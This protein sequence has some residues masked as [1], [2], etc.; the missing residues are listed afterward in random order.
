LKALGVLPEKWKFA[1]QNFQAVAE[2][3]AI[4]HSPRWLPALLFSGVV[5]WQLLAA[6][7]FGWAP[8]S[9]LGAGVLAWASLG[10]A[11]TVGLGLWVAFI[12]ADEIFMQYDNESS[13][14]L[15][16]VALLVTLVSLYVLPP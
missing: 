11:F 9:S 8:I 1:S 7:L 16:F 6:V 15:L 4:Y 10:I 2:A 14:V 12:I 13:H 5:F 3:T